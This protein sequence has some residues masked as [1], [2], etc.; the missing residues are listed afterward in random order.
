MY[1]LSVQQTIEAS[2]GASH[3][4]GWRT[5]VVAIPYL[6]GLRNSSF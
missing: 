1:T 5:L 6:Q 2:S 4:L 3:L